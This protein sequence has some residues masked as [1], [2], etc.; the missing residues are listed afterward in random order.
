MPAADGVVGGIQKD[1]SL[2]R[3]KSLNFFK[4]VRQ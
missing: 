3:D 2:I 4:A 1:K